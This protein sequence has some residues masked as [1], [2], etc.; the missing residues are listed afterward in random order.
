MCWDC[1]LSVEDVGNLGEI[2]VRGKNTA[3][4]TIE[5]RNWKKLLLLLFGKQSEPLL[6]KH[7]F[8]K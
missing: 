4:D 7:G 3:V 5:L 6:R 2:K 1:L 8:V